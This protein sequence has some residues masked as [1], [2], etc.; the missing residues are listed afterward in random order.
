MAV[1]N[2]RDTDW[3]RTVE[4]VEGVVDACGFG[5][6]RVRVPRTFDEFSDVENAL[7]SFL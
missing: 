5:F 6:D 7:Y 4:H 1:C 2:D 3:C